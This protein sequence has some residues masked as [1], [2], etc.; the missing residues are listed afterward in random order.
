MDEQLGRWLDQELKEFSQIMGKFKKRL[1]RRMP[2]WMAVS[3]GGMIALG[4]GVGYDIGYVLRVHFVIGLGIALVIG[5]CYWIQIS[6]LS[7]KKVRKIYEKGIQTYL[8]GQEDR[9]AFCRQMESGNYGK[10]EF[11]NTMTCRYPTRFLAG[12][13]YLMYFDGRGGCRFLRTSNIQ[14]VSGREE[15]TR[16]RVGNASK[17]MTVGV[18]MVLVCREEASQA[19]EEKEVEMFF[20]NGDQFREAARLID[21]YRSRT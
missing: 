4:I 9:D 12:P 19:K 7:V 2:L 14:S 15:T 6:G 5:L 10:A 1:M 11:M 16:V 18:S 8:V 21:R 20:E 3:I 13:E 17:R